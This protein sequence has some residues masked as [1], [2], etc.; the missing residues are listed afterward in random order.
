MPVSICV[1]FIGN[2][3]LNLIAK[4]P[5]FAKPINFIRLNSRSEKVDSLIFNDYKKF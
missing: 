4:I 5:R 3:L 1:R 2:I